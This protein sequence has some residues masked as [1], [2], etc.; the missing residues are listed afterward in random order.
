[1]RIIAILTV[2]LLCSFQTIPA[3]SKELSEAQS[4]VEQIVATHPGLVR[5]TIHAVPMGETQSRIIACNIQ[6]KLGK[7]SDPEDLDAIKS[8]KTVVLREGKNLDVTMPILDK[9]GKAIAATGITLALG[10]GTN[11]DALVKEAQGIAQELTEA[12]RTAGHPLW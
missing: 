11:E 3:S 4:L 1:M 12:I 2:L 5:L 7:L 10:D 6:E 9:T 8:K